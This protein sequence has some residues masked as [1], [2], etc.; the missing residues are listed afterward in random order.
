MNLTFKVIK[1]NN[2]SVAQNLVSLRTFINEI[3][4]QHVKNNSKFS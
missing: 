2:S 4:M 3:N 1:V